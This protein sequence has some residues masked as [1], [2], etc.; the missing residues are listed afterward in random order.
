MLVNNN[1]EAYLK[2]HTGNE[3]RNRS[4]CDA[5]K[6]LWWNILENYGLNL[7]RISIKNI[8]KM[9]FNDCKNHSFEQRTEVEPIYNRF[10]ENL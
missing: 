2:Q 5:F 6:G 9:N 8:Y 7:S 3:L 4:V 1:E 10:V